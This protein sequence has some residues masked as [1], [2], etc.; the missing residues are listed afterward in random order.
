MTIFA[1]GLENWF[2]SGQEIHFMLTEAL[3]AV[4]K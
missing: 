2:W 4:G 3:T 1:R